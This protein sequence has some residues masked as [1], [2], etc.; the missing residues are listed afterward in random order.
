M[1]I[2]EIA[3]FCYLLPALPMFVLQKGTIGSLGSDRGAADAR[4]QRIRRM[5][6]LI[7]HP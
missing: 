4:A 6:R 3:D 1:H 2:D 5:Q 7:N